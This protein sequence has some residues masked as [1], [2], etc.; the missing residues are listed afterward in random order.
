MSAIHPISYG[1]IPLQDQDSYK[2][3]PLELEKPKRD[4]GMLAF[5]AGDAGHGHPFIDPSE[6]SALVAFLVS[7]EA[8]YVTGLNVRRDTGRC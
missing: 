4:D 2:A 3:F 6:V 7:E 8:P 1:S 5:P